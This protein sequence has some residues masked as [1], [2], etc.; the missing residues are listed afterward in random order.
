[1]ARFVALTFAG[2][3]QG[4]VLSF[5]CLGVVLLYGATGIINFA[6]GELM[7]F[8]ALF[9]FRM[10][11]RDHWDIPRAYLLVLAVAF[12]I[13]VVL[14]RVGY[15]PLRN[16]PKRAIVVATLTWYF[17]LRAI[18]AAKVGRGSRGLHPW[19]GNDGDVI[20]IFGAVIMPHALLVL[21]VAAAVH[22]TMAAILKLTSFGRQ[23]R[24]LAVDREIALLYGV[25]VKRFT[26]LIFGLAAMFAAAAGILAAPVFPIGTNLAFNVMLSAFGAA[27][28]GGFES[29]QRTLV[30]AF[31]LTLS[32][33][34]LI[35]Y[36]SPAFGEAYPLIIVLAVLMFR[37]N[38]LGTK[39]SLTAEAR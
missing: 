20:H 25:R 36:F 29:Y 35:G 31:L 16:Q 9:A 39:V 11:R 27:A 24:A 34:Y 21:A 32:Q 14:E 23:I 3:T 38:G 18:I 15:A 33:Q 12:L 4:A 22:L 6:H 30:A 1:M 37:P 13:G 28:I 19:I 7:T 26:T 8:G 2:L 17:A 10:T 5:V